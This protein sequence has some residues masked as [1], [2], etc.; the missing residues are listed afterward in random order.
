MFVVWAGVFVFWLL[1]WI[2]GL[3]FAAGFLLFALVNVWITIRYSFSRKHISAIPF[4][5][6]ISGVLACMILPDGRLWNLW[7]VPLVLDLG[8]L[9]MSVVFVVAHCFEGEARGDR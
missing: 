1:R 4:L 3:A 7:W 6:G 9:P 8:S 2:L 5:G